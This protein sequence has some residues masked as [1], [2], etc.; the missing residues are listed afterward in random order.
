MLT[1][2]IINTGGILHTNGTF[3]AYAG[4]NG[5][6]F[7]DRFRARR[8]WGRINVIPLRQELPQFLVMVIG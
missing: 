7:S 8:Q 1:V 5:A 3:Q 4:L 6:V 2:D